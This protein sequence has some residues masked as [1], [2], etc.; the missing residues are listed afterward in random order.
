MAYFKNFT[1]AVLIVLNPVMRLA[2][3]KFHDLRFGC[4]V[5]SAIPYVYT[6]DSFGAQLSF[7]H[8]YN[9]ILVQKFQTHQYNHRIC[10]RSS[11]LSMD[12]NIP[13]LKGPQEISNV[14]VP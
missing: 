9:D 8:S 14:Y 5:A 12:P 3:I 6:V 7:L 2:H 1:I 4:K 13:V 10:T 11:T